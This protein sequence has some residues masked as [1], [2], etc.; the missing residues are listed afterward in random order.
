MSN[1]I[2]TAELLRD[3]NALVSHIAETKLTGKRLD[4]AIQIMLASACLHAH[5]H[6]DFDLI[7]ET[8]TAMNKGSRTNAAREFVERFGP[9]NWNE[10]NKNF[11]FSK[12]KRIENFEESELFNTMLSTDWTELKPEA[13]FRPFD[14]QA[15][16][17]AILR[18]AKEAAAD[19]EHADKHKVSES[20]IDALQIIYDTMELERKRKEVEK[21][22]TEQK[23]EEVA[24]AE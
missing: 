19:Q 10:K 17:A 7:N 5:S 21:A 13:P 20:E 14:L 22:T 2:T 23:A 11:V 6:G 24:A 18:K 4:K 15:Q 12:K 16:L 1:V 8:I 9:V 3:K